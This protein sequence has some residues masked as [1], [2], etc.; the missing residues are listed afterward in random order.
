MLWILLYSR[1]KT[2]IVDTNTGIHLTE[3]ELV[4]I[5]NEITA[6]A[7]T[8]ADKIANVP[9]FKGCTNMQ[10]LRAVLEKKK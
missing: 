2:A 4:E 1:L 9:S 10:D 7:I 3:H 5:P 8:E 6:T